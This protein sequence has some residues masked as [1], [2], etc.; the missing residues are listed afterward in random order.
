M[1]GAPSPGLEMP[2]GKVIHKR[3]IKGGSIGWILHTMSSG[4]R[5]IFYRFML[6]WGRAWSFA[7]GPGGRQRWMS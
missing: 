1:E 3:T 4:S 6:V 7:C 5:E 2:D